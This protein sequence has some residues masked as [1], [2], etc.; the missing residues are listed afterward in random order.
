MHWKQA[1]KLPKN[2]RLPLQGRGQPEA[3]REAA[4]NLQL[5]YVS[6][7]PIFSLAREK[8]GE[9]RALSYGLVHSASEFRQEPIL[10]LSFHSILTLRILTTRRLIHG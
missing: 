1:A 7:G 3:D 8:I 6:D 9:K 5:L 4:A 2:T 10:G